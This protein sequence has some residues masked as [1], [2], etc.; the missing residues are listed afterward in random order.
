MKN[1]PVDSETSS[2]EGHIKGKTSENNQQ[3]QTSEKHPREFIK[4]ASDASAGKG[5]KIKGSVTQKGNISESAVTTEKQHYTIKLTNASK[6]A[7]PDATEQIDNVEGEAT[8]QKKHVSNIK[9][10]GDKIVKDSTPTPNAKSSD[11]HLKIGDI[12]GEKEGIVSPPSSTKSTDM[13]L[14][15]G[16]IKG[17]K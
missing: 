17:E 15:I 16:D 3:L 2:I 13:F 12:K 6:K 7:N 1:F 10:S 9:W 5:S 11:I 14:K 4:L 8:T